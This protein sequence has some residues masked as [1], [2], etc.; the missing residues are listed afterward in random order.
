[1]SVP[2]NKKFT[3]AATPLPFSACFSGTSPATLTLVLPSLLLSQPSDS[4]CC[5]AHHGVNA[6]AKIQLIKSST[7]EKQA[8]NQPYHGWDLFPEP[9]EWKSSNKGLCVHH[10]NR[11]AHY[12]S[13]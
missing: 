2:G 5:L 3:A 8:K 13:I 6:G 1:M 12:T 11:I 9:E 7:H 4:L 10:L